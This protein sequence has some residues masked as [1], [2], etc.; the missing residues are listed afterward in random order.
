MEQDKP[1]KLL[2]IVVLILS[3]IV[4]Y[5]AL[6]DIPNIEEES[7]S[8]SIVET[9]DSDSD[10]AEKTGGSEEDEA[11]GFASL[12][13]TLVMW[14]EA[15]SIDAEEKTFAATVLTADEGET[16]EE[17]QEIEIVTDSATEFYKIVNQ[18]PTADDYFDF[19][20]FNTLME[21]WEGPD[22]R[23]TLKGN[24]QEDGSVLAREIFYQIQ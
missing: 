21:T 20:K 22:W 12:E 10:T 8:I 6:M 23:F 24:T 9:D 18:A 13:I 2:A 3:T 14:P 1:K 15:G 19:A 11:A 4:V 16:F 5:F 7:T 17:G